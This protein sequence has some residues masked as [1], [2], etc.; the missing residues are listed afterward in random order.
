M[1]LAHQMMRE[2]YADRAYPV[3]YDLVRRHPGNAQVVLGYAALGLFL[4]APNPMFAAPVAGIGTCVTIEGSDGN[5]QSFVIDEGGDFFGISV[6]PPGIGIAARVAGL[7]RGETFTLDKLGSDPETWTVAE[8]ISKYLY[9][10]HRVLE[11]FETR[12]PDKPGIARYTVGEDNVDSVLELVR[13]S[14]EQNARNARTYLEQPIPLSVV[15]RGLGGDVISFAQF[16]RRL[17][18]QIITCAGSGDER[19]A[20]VKLARR[21]QGK[22]AV[23]DPYT[24]WVA[25]EIGVL[26]ELKAWFG[27]LRTP[28][29]TIAM[30][31]RMID[32]ENE[33]RG[34]EQ[35]TL[36]WHKGQ[37]FRDEVTDEYRDS[38][39]SALTRVRDAIVENCEVVSVLVPNEISE[40]AENVIAMAGSRFFD[41]AFL[42][43]DTGSILLS[44]DMRYRQWSSETV[45]CNGI[46]LQAAL[47]AAVEG[48]AIKPKDYAR[49]VAG[50][51]THGH[52]HVAF[53]GLVLYLIA[54]QDTDGFPGLRATLRFLAGPSA[55][56]VSHRAVFQNFLDWLWPPDETLPPLKTKAATGLALEAFLNDRK[57]DWLPLLEEVVRNN[58]SDRSLSEYLAS[59]L[60]GHFITKEA[61]SGGLASSEPVRQV[62][63]QKKHR[64]ARKGSRRSK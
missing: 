47:L 36:S 6:L 7:R 1:V 44:D 33:G 17:G 31:D 64:R 48:R 61:F 15:A 46:W 12:F 34:R 26:P 25:C 58:S 62:S 38:N 14:A 20:G 50:L 45:G 24:A 5:Q 29:S 10:Q 60:Y 9:L 32:R 37:F 21:Y 51:A 49:S 2:G 43:S 63:H 8:V 56:M 19:V 42:A 22:G 23:L 54:S 59:W 52:T 18:G 35:M 3:A 57:T 55:E 28:A 16:V 30:I 40:M 53:S 27:T 41:A 11:Q 39:I 4:Q 13:R